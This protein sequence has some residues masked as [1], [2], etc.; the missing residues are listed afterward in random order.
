MEQKLDAIKEGQIRLEAG[1]GYQHQAVM[2]HLQNIHAIL[3]AQAGAS[4]GFKV[5]LA[6]ALPVVVFLIMLAITG[7][8]RSAIKLAKVVG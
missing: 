2:W 7:D 6:L 1:M 5:P 4:T 3:Q 8:L